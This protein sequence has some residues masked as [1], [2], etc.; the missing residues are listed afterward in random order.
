MNT[1][2]L[3]DIFVS[4]MGSAFVLKPDEV[5]GHLGD[6]TTVN[7]VLVDDAAGDRA[8]FRP[9]PYANEVWEVLHRD[10]SVPT[11]PDFPVVVRKTEDGKDWI[12]VRADYN[13]LARQE[14][15]GLR[16]VAAH[17]SQHMIRDEHV[18]DDP[19]YVYRRALVSLRGQI[20]DDGTLRVYVQPGSLPYLSPNWYS[21]GFGPHLD[22]LIPTSGERW[23]HHYLDQSAAI[24]VVAGD[25]HATSDR[26]L[27]PAPASPEWTVPIVNVLLYSTTTALAEEANMYDARKVVMPNMR[28]DAPGLWS[29]KQLIMAFMKEYDA[30]W[31]LHL[32]GEA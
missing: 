19:V 12:V 7:R 20:A 32:K 31:T 11:W 8:Y 4:A 25:Q 2:T 22:G 24:K 9:Q 27:Y 15:M 18:P 1:K 21:G 28:N 5:P 29:I 13:S 14:D 6:G 26:E 30:M 3:A 10:S 23:V 17:A 16:Y